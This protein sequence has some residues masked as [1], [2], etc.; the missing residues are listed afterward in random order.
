MLTS[1]EIPVNA[2]FAI[3]PPL[4]IIVFIFV[5]LA[6]AVP[7]NPLPKSFVLVYGAS[8]YST[9]VKPYKQLPQSVHVAGMTIFF[10]FFHPLNAPS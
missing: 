6:L 4:T 3:A 1:S 9:F 2:L 7:N 10:K 8:T 5:K